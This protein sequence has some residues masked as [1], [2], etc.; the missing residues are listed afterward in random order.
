MKGLQIIKTHGFD[1][2]AS[3]LCEDYNLHS[4]PDL[5]RMREWLMLKRGLQKLNPRN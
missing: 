4:M 1:E 2:I 5:V 3:H